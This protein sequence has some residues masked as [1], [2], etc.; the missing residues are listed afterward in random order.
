MLNQYCDLKF[1]IH[2]IFCCI[3]KVDHMMSEVKLLASFD[4][5]CIAD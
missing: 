2:V 5:V 1:E 3:A 4:L